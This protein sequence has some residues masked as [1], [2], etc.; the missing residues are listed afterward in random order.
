MILSV[1]AP[2]AHAI[3]LGEIKP[4]LRFVEQNKKSGYFLHVPEGFTQEKKW[5]LILGFAEWGTDIKKYAESW[6]GEADRQGYIVLC[7]Q[8]WKSRDAVPDK[9]DRWIL[10]IMSKITKE[11]NVDPAKILV[12]GFADGGDYAYYLALRY[13]KRFAS[14]AVLGGALGRN[15]DNLI[16]YGRVRRKPVSFFIRNG[17]NDL[18]LED[19]QHT[20]ESI[21]K[22]VANLRKLG[23]DVDYGEIDGLGHEYRKDFNPQIIDWFETKYKG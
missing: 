1:A 18:A 2:D 17:K 12:T 10:R 8:W 4:G 9:G 19:R 6:A 23:L 16:F 11:L 13:P 15:F 20:W 21:H 7:P 22:E 14:A 5:P 3:F